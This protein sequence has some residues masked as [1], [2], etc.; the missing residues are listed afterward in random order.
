MSDS[1][2]R[3]GGGTGKRPYVDLV[4]GAWR[5]W[6]AATQLA[7]ALGVTLPPGPARALSACDE[8][9]DAAVGDPLIFR[10]HAAAARIAA[11]LPAAGVV[12]V[13]TPRFGL[14][15]R[16]DNEWFFLFLKRRGI[17]IVFVGD[18]PEVTV[19][20]RSVFERRGD[21][22]EPPLG[23]TLGALSPAQE[24]L[25]RFFPGLLPRS[26]AEK[27]RI[28]IGDAFLVPVGPDHFLIPPGWR[29]SDPREA[30]PDLDA[31]ADLEAADAGLAS[32]AQRY[33]T[34]HFADSATLCGLSAA[35]EEGGALDIA[36]E[37][38]ERARQ[39]A[40]TPAEMAT[41]DIRR[42]EIRRRLGRAAQMLALPPPS[43]RASNE[44]RHRLDRLKLGAALAV[45]R[46]A[47][48][49]AD[50]GPLAAKLGA[51]EPMAAGRPPAA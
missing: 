50:L 13:L 33:C 24:R 21:V 18:E 5:P 48:L 38:A 17:A 3:I 1:E 4:L 27:Q 25:L 12:V 23:A 19:I 30:A 29:D 7:A 47:G 44:A 6:E 32:L 35:I 37:L 16:H 31:M 14:P 10:A 15:L 45:G 51:G 42:Q 26:L 36:S 40:L 20:G 39:V 11:A 41:A 28:A 9:D 46:T 8:I 34:A 2:T 49:H 22:G 43:R